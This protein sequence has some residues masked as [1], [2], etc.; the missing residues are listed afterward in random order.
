MCILF[1]VTG[2]KIGICKRNI[3]KAE[4]GEHPMDEEN[5]LRDLAAPE[6]QSGFYVLFIMHMHWITLQT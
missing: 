4:E 2:S 5:Q 1:K 3:C 6:N